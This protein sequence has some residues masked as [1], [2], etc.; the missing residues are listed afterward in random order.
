MSTK[1]NPTILDLDHEQ[2]RRLLMQPESY[3]TVPLPEYYDFTEVL[4]KSEKLAGKYQQS[5]VRQKGLAKYK[6]GSA[7]SGG[8]RGDSCEIIH[9]YEG[10]NHRIL[11]NKD[12]LL[13]WRPMELINPVIYSSIVYELTIED[14]WVLVK[15][16]FAE[17]QQ[18][19]NLECCSIPRGI[20]TYMQKSSILN[21]W[22]SFEQRSIALSLEFPYMGKTDISDCYGAMYTHSISWALHGKEGAKI[23]RSRRG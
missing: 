16:R 14:N 13:S 17:F 19:E 22:E 2:A 11:S 1:P 10:V 6:N 3:C 8:Y 12:G 7:S 9:V 23:V 18:N 15:E 5:C 4:S 20:F 21:W